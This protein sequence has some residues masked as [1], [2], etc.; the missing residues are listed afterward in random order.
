MA[1]AEPI[2]SDLLYAWKSMFGPQFLYVWATVPKIRKRWLKGNAYMNPSLHV[3]KQLQIVL[4]N[5]EK[6]IFIT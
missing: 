3:T 4:D 6:Y 1:S 5:F 2:F